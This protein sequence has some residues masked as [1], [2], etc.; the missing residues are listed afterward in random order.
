MKTFLIL[1]IFG[2]TGLMLFETNP[3]AKRP[4]LKHVARDVQSLCCAPTS[5]S[6]PNLDCRRLRPITQPVVEG[7][8]YLYTDVPKDYVFFTRYTTRLP[9]QTLYGVGIAGQFVSW[10]DRSSTAEPCD[11]FYNTLF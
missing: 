8:L 11:I 3:K 10:P 4:Y 9:N 7:I 5:A 6:T 1:I 2:L